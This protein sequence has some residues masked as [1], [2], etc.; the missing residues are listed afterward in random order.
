MLV[1]ARKEDDAIHIGEN[2]IVKVVSIENGI[3]KLGIEAPKEISIMRHELIAEV[4]RSNQ[5]ALQKVDAQEIAALSQ[6]L[7]KI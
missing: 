6:L 5:A 1:L 3:V 2:I 7:K 4:T